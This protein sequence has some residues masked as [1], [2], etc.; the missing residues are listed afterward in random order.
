MTEYQVCVENCGCG[1]EGADFYE[2][3][4]SKLMQMTFW[5]HKEVLFEKI[6][7]KIKEE[8]GDKLDKIADLLVEASNSKW[9][10]RQEAEK[11]RGEL[12]GKLKDAFGN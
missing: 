5:A 1:S 11:E 4:E 3:M 7:D 12:R 6:K 8:E 2:V 10:S 9:K